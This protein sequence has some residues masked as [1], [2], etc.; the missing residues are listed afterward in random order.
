MKTIQIRKITICDIFITLFAFHEYADVYIHKSIFLLGSSIPMMLIGLYF[1]YQAIVKYK[2]IAY[3]KALIVFIAF[4][5]VY[6]TLHWMGGETLGRVKPT[7]F[8][9]GNW[10]SLTP[11]LVF[12]I[13]TLRGEVNENRMFIYFVIFIIMG[14][15]NYNYGYLRR[16]LE[17]EEDFS[18][19]GFTNSAAYIFVY[20]LPSLFLFVKKPIIQYGSLLI[21]LYFVMSG[22]KRGAIVIAAV[23]M[24]FFVVFSL[25]NNRFNQSKKST[26][27]IVLTIL[28]MVLAAY[29]LYGF[30]QT[31][32]LSNDYFYYRLENTQAGDDSGR[33]E[34]Y[35][36]LL[37][38]F[39]NNE[40]LFQMIFGLGAEGT[41]RV[42]HI[43]AHNDW[44]ELLT[45]CGILGVFIYL[46]YF[47]YFY[48]TC[49][50]YKKSTPE[51]Y[52]ILTMC[53]VLLIKSFFS[54]SFMNMYLGASSILG[55]AMAV[56]QQKYNNQDT[57][58]D[59]EE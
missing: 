6:G 37:F 22:M 17:I 43:H 13:C 42:V 16:D 40:N 5:S 8:L 15:L 31:V 49:R 58:I 53:V 57:C 14:V 25:Q 28:L 10:N 33:G 50:K 56:C 54:M 9:F 12:Y 52:I 18:N 51:A 23:F 48:K 11:I 38:N 27:K 4:L 1:Y 7:A 41:M 2:T 47:Y 55:Y 45:D 26:W 29:L 3:I 19:V 39:A 59:K 32:W 46:V 35:K 21:M 30:I 44:L 36:D 24:V 20:L 34:I